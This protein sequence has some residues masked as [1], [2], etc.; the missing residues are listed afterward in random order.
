MI[1]ALRHWARP[2][3]RETLG[4]LFALAASIISLALYG[5]NPALLGRLDE[6]TRD[7]VY[8]LRQAPPPPKDIVVVSVDEPSIKR[9]GR[10]PWSRVLQARLIRALKSQGAGLIALD[11][12]YV[13]PESAQ[14]DRALID[15]L[16]APGAPVVGGY[17]LREHQTVPASDEAMALL[18]DSAVNEVSEPAGSISSTVR[19]LPY[20][21]A[22]QAEIAAPMAGLG[23]FNYFPDPDGLLRKAPM[24]LRQDD[25]LLYPSLPLKALAVWRHEQIAVGFDGKG[26][27]SLRLGRLPIPVDETGKMV[28]NFYNGKQQIPL[29][30]AADA[31]DGSLPPGALRGKLVLVGVTETGIADVRP[32]PTHESFPGI[33]VHATVAA[34][35]LQHFFLVHDDRT[36]TID[37]LVIGLLPLAMV[38][39]MTLSRRP[40]VMVGVFGLT[41]LGL[42]WSYYWVV[43]QLNMLVSL[44]YPAVAVG[45]G[46]ILFQSYYAVVEQ[47]QVRFLKHA[48][49]SYVSPALVGRIINNPDALALQGEKRRVT[50]LFSDIRGF[51]TLSES[52]PPERLVA[53]LNGYLGPMT[54]IVMA[55]HGTLDKY[56]GDAVMAIYNAPLDMPDHAMRAATTALRMQR[57]LAK[58]NSGFQR[59]FGVSLR[60]GVGLNT[61]EA[62]VGNMG[63]ARRFDYTVIGD[64]VNLASRLEG[65]TKAYGIGIVISDSTRAELGDRFLCRRLDRLRV[66]GKAQPVEIHELLRAG[67]DERLDGL[68]RRFGAALEEYFEGRFGTAESMF[69]ELLRDFPEDGPSL[70]FVERCRVYQTA[71]PAPDWAGVYV[72]TTK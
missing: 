27:R 30:S 72:A 3:R 57:G 46:F 6:R 22:S 33:A 9:Y 64:T 67:R 24:V 43:G 25:G 32:T 31:L 19:S 55:E 70:A 11:I 35:I 45:V 62:I 63:S 2:L 68:A 17:F 7:V 1:K 51:T 5:L 52:L 40:V 56:I 28:V 65:Q 15:A 44:A 39:L 58:L 29:L 54:D 69:S 50:V 20:V 37:V 23:F 8:D 60:I 18:G 48:F 13:R 21:E 53:L 42:W 38:W 66:Q 26:V 61:G 59:D 4:L 71:P 49:S 36:L 34:D 10:W 14:A 47:R 12:V 41:L 16:A